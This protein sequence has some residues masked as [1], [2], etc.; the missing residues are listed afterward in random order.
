MEQGY[1]K[2]ALGEAI[3]GK[4]LEKLTLWLEKRSHYN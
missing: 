4:R 2:A 3:K 1:Q